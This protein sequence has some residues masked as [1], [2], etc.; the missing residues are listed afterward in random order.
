MIHTRLIAPVLI[1]LL[2]L[3]SNMTMAQALPDFTG[4]IERNSPGVV[5]ISTTLKQDNAS[6]RGF[7]MPNLPEDSPLYDFFDK[8]FNQNPEKP[9]PFI[10]R[11]SLGSGFIIS[12][13]GYII[14]N[15][16]V[17]SEADEIIVRLNDRREFVAE[18]IGSDPRSDIAVIKIDG[19]DLPVLVLGDSSNLKVGEWVLAIGSPFGFDY[20]VTQGIISAMGRSLPNDSYVPFIQTDVAINP[21]N[22]GGPLFNLE[23][24]VIGVNSQIYSRNGGYMGLSFAVPI[25]VVTDVYR[26]LR[27]KG[28]VS[29][30]WLGV[31]IQDVTRELAES[32]SMDLPRGALVARVLPDTPAENAR[33]QAGDVIVRFNRQDV[34]TSTDLPPIVGSTP[35][36]SRVPVDII[37][38]GREQTLMVTIDELPDN[39]AADNRATE[40][41]PPEPEM[42]ALKIVVADPDD[43]ERELLQLEDYG[44]V[45][46]SVSEG[47]AADAGI[48]QGDVILLINNEQVNDTA[49]FEKLIENLPDNKSIPVL[50]QRRGNPTFLAIRL[51]D[52]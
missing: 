50:I 49:E 22:S 26:Q 14:T 12:K 11:S 31:I 34:T 16:H 29:R 20:S 24:E 38:S 10:E 48:R 4:L 28:S 37:R 45:V 51:E 35:T 17:V 52:E 9:Q 33:L 19:E 6:Q 39:L 36:G 46:E 42:N 18:L 41:Q 23:G 15:N 8:F 27:D 3:T 30:G 44:I 2:Y 40:E 5:N 43:E 7:N 47:P 1:I 25:D 21:G 13:D 32:F